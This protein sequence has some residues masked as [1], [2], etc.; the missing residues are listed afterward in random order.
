MPPTFVGP[1][2]KIE[3]AQKHIRDLD[4]RFTIF[5]QSDFY[6]LRVN[7]DEESGDSILQLEHTEPIPDD[8][9]LITGDALLNL[10]SALDLLVSDVVYYGLG[11]RPKKLYFPIRESYKDLKGIVKT[12]EIQQANP[13]IADLI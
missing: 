3:R 10:R 8:F 1:K 12:G 7:E 5:A 4:E 2:L 6:S 11:T 13:A 9:A